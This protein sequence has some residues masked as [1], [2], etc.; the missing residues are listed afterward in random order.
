MLQYDKIET[1]MEGKNMAK[2]LQGKEVSDALNASLKEEVEK[3]NRNGIIPT[4]GIIRVGERDDD[5]AYERSAIKR[6]ETIGVAVKRFV[7][8]SNVTQEELVQTINKANQDAA[9]HG[10]LLFQPLPSHI[11]ANLVRRTLSTDKDVDGITEGSMVGVFTDTDKGF[12]PC[13]PRACMEILDYYNIDVTGKKTVI[14][15]RSLVVGKPLAMMLIKKNATVTVCHT[16]T[17]DMPA[18]CRE[19]EL[20]IVAAGKAGTVN[21]QFI[22]ERQI[23]IDVGINVDHEGNL[24][25][26]VAFEQVEPFVQAITPVPGGVGTVTTSVS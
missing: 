4:L 19:A 13:T 26:D 8:N 12:P 18:I 10:I 15:G 5:I 24:C 11:D 14:I 22:N 9:I 6:C 21:Q 2:L 3:L 1:E 25:G 20:L 16:K 7:L 23:I 17:L